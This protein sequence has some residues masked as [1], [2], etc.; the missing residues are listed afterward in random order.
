MSGSTT[1]VKTSRLPHRRGTG[2]RSRRP[3]SP[4]S[5]S[6]AVTER[7]TG[8][9]QAARPISR[10]HQRRQVGRQVDHQV[11]RGAGHPADAGADDGAVGLGDDRIADHGAGRLAHTP[12]GHQAGPGGQLAVDGRGDLRLAAGIVPHPHLVQDTLEVAQRRA[13]GPDE[14]A[15]AGRVWML[16]ERGDW[17]RPPGS[18][19][20]CRSGTAARSC[21]RRWRRRDT[22]RRWRSA[23]CRAPDGSARRPC[24]RSRRP[25]RR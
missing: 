24:P 1:R 4:P 17:H 9:D 16:S 23:S 6:L 19:P 10:S 21:R 18:P 12:A 5:G 25:A 22:T 2:R 8:A 13:A 11:E 7:V 14:G 15:Q 20:G 3:R